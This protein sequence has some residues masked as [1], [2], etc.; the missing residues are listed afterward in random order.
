MYRPELPRSVAGIVDI[1][2]VLQHEGEQ[3]SCVAD[4][5]D[6]LVIADVADAG[7]EWEAHV[8]VRILLGS[9]S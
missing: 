5:V 7:V 1:L 3:D 8:I 6:V 4:G 2:C 9:N